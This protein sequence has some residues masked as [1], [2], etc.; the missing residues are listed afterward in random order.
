LYRQL[1]RTHLES[2]FARRPVQEIRPAQLSVLL[3]DLRRSGLS[4]WTRRG[5]YQVL[6]SI[7]EHAR[8]PH[9]LLIDSPLKRLGKAERPKAKSATKARTLTND[10]CARLIAATSEHWRSMVTT[11][12]FTGLRISELLGLAWADIDFD[13]ETIHV[14][15]QLSRGSADEPARLV[16]LKSDAGERDAY[17]MPELAAVLRRHRAEALSLGKASPESYVFST[18]Q[19]RPLSQRNATRALTV[20]AGRAGLN[21]EGVERLSF[22]DLRHT[23]ISRLIAAGL[24][25]VEVQRQAGHSRPSITLD[26]YSHE[27]G[28]RQ[29]RAED[30]RTKIAA[31]GLGSVLAASS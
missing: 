16:P 26:H 31:T 28:L 27:F 2:T 19:G 9:G 21:P 18:L 20:A 12:V 3:A 15:N 24:D 11:A 23:A 13:E 4:S 17:L 22:H 14:R 5:I 1:Y 8:S 30:A 7:F 29:Q 10:E 25:I 6:A